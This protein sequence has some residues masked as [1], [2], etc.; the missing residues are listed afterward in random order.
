MQKISCQSD[1]WLWNYELKQQHF[2]LCTAQVAKNFLIFNFFKLD[3]V[4]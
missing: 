1:K 2:I 4:S 3:F